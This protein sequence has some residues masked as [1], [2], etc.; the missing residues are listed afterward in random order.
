MYHMLKK[1]EEG[2]EGA[3]ILTGS[4]NKLLKTGAAFVRISEGCD[5]ERILE[6]PVP[7]RFVI[8]IM[9]PEFDEVMKTTVSVQDIGSHFGALLSDEVSLKKQRKCCL[10]V[11]F[12]C[13]VTVAEIMGCYLNDIKPLCS[14]LQIFACVAYLSREAKDLAWAVDEFI[15]NTVVLPPGKWDRR[16]VLEPS[17][18]PVIK[19]QNMIVMVR[20]VIKH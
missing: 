12:F 13:V 18:Q 16:N 7:L 8:I 20:A 17:E 4:S 2:S 5:F 15:S 19:V 6:V 14:T 10:K 9:T 11:L 1:L 3:V